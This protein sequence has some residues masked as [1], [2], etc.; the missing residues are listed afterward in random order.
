MSSTVDKQGDASTNAGGAP[1]NTL[2]SSFFPEDDPLHV[3]REA[4][5]QRASLPPSPPPLPPSPVPGRLSRVSYS[6]EP[7]CTG[8]G[9]NEAGSSDDD[10]DDDAKSTADEQ[11]T[12][13]FDGRPFP[14]IGAF[15][16]FAHTVAQPPWSRTEVD[17]DLVMAGLQT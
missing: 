1:A 12:R 14:S 4:A 16:R 11:R 17:V 10:D 15:N 7:G 6:F 13:F 8:G 3:A 9:S 2:L 5:N